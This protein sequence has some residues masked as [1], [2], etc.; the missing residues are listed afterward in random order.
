M[1]EFIVTLFLYRVIMGARRAWITHYIKSNNLV[2]KESDSVQPLAV[3]SSSTIITKSLYYFIP[4][5][6][7]HWLRDSGYLYVFYKII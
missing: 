7:Q 1:S 5:S 3:P 6:V 4:I 2:N